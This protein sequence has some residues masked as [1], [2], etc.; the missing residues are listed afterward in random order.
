M[1]NW[2]WFGRTGSGKTTIVN[3]ICRFYEPKKGE[4]I[5]NNGNYKEYNISSIRKRIG[6]VMQ[7]TQI[8]PNTIID[9]IR[10]VNKNITQKQIEN[11][12]K[13]LKLHDK[14]TNFENGYNTDIYNNPDIL[15]TRRKANYKFCKSNGNRC[16]CY[17][18]RWSIF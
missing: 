11:I 14:I 18:F 13:K 16:W 15:S 17:Y 9:N 2:L 10:Y 12:F 7:E 3:L 1:K 4:I 8:L 5:I 6:Y